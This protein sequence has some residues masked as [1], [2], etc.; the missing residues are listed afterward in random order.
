[1]IM[2]KINYQE[3]NWA[4]R[5]FTSQ[6]RQMGAFIY[7]FA[8]KLTVTAAFPAGLYFEIINTLSLMGLSTFISKDNLTVNNVVT[9]LSIYWGISI[10][11]LIFF[12]IYLPIYLSI[13]LSI[14][15]FFLFFFFFF[16]ALL[17]HVYTG[18]PFIYNQICY[19]KG[20]S[21]LQVPDTGTSQYW[22]ILEHYWC[23]SIARKCDIYVP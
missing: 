2:V 21:I 11:Y 13:Y 7:L 5:I 6:H 17:K 18:L 9:Y 14:I 10:N 22:W 16:F 8:V 15:S 4:L 12:F 23:T 19:Y 3:W 1:M 20:K